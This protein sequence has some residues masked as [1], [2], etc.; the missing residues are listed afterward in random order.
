MLLKEKDKEKAVLYVKEM[1]RSVRAH[2]I[3]AEQMIIGTQLTRAIESY[4]SIGPHVAV[5]QRMVQKGMSVPPGTIINFIVAE[6]SGV[7]RER[8]CSLEEMGKKLYDANYYIDHQIIPSVDRILAVVGVDIK[9]EVLPQ[10]S[11]QNFFT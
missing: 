3:P 4:G 10:K 5:A 7:V 2:K 9:N 1:V 11:L 8:A 6:G